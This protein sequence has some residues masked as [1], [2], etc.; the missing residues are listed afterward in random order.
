M[1]LDS[2]STM[3]KNSSE[4]N[5]YYKYTTDLN[6]NGVVLTDATKKDC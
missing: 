6:T 5:S 4:Y 1:L 2:L 3:K